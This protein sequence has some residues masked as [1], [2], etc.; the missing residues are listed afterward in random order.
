M[1][2]L[3]SAAEILNKAAPPGESLAYIN[4]E[5]AAVLKNMG[6]LGKDINNSGVPSNQNTTISSD[7]VFNGQAYNTVSIG[8]Y[9]AED[10]DI[11]TA[12]FSKFPGEIAYA[13]GFTSPEDFSATVAFSDNQA[14]GPVAD[15]D[16]DI[17]VDYF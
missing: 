15:I 3:K 12:K 17:E 6:G 7:F 14:T 2:N 1:Y 5:E 11:E 4:P 9:T 13:S 10:E 8:D 16:L